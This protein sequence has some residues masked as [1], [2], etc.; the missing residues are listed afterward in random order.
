MLNS[1]SYVSNAIRN[2]SKAR[3]RRVKERRSLSKVS[4][5]SFKRES[6]GGGASLI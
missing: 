5:L 4:F 1:E 6:K 2:Q 3:V